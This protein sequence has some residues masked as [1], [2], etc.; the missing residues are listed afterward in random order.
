MI[1]ARRNVPAAGPLLARDLGRGRSWPEQVRSI[2]W[3][4]NPIR[5]AVVSGLLAAALLATGCVGKS[6]ARTKQARAATIED[7]ASLSVVVV[8]PEAFQAELVDRAGAGDWTLQT[9][10]F[11]DP[12]EWPSG[13]PAFRTRTPFLEGRGEATFEHLPEG[14]YAIVA[15]LDLDGDGELDRGAFG[16]PTEPVAYGND[17]KP[18]FGPPSFDAC[19]VEA[20]SGSRE[21]TLTLVVE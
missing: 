1:A 17:A 12:R 15:F 9:A 11:T 5:G 4:R 19:V 8:A 20:G 7:E 13:T 3:P 21:V 16:I 14:A 18:R 6:T 10:L 2:L